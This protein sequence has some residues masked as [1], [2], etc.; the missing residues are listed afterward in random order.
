MVG[1]SAALRQQARRRL[2]REAPPPPLAGPSDGP[3]T[4]LVI[5]DHVPEYD[6]HAGALTMLHYLKI[7][8]AQGLRV[9]FRPDDGARL[10]PYSREIEE[11]GVQLLTGEIDMDDWIE[12]FGAQLDWVML[13]RPHVARRWLRRVRRSSDARVLYL[14]HDLHY[15]REQRRYQT[16]GGPDAQSESRRLLEIETDLVRDVDTVLTFSSDEVAEIEGLA[17]GVDVRVVTPAFYGGDRSPVPAPAAQAPMAQRADIVFVGAYDHLPNVDAASTLVREVM[18]QVW[19]SVPDTHVYLVGGHVP[20]SVS[21]LASDRVTVTGHVPSL[22]P[23][24]ARARASVSALR[25]GSG[26]KGKIIASLEAGVPVVTTTIGNEGIGLRDGVEAL[27]GDT[28]DELAG[29]VI[30]LLSDPDLADSLAAAGAA[31]LR[32]RFSEDQVRQGLDAVLGLA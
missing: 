26:T 9:V 30:S 18:P 32:G 5:D 17:P 27:L 14:A 4:I 8:R 20:A 29:H 21:E 31:V 23:Y 28:P 2:R 7:M 12:A 3:G 19:A 24:W 16:T 11:C 15:L 1:R 25:F 10:E 6:V 22:E 13:S